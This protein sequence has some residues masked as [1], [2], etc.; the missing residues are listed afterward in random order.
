MSAARKAK[1]ISFVRRRLFMR[2]R[3]DTNSAFSV[4]P[5]NNVHDTGAAAFSRALPQ[6]TS[7][8]SLD[9]RRTVPCVCACEIAGVGGANNACD[10]TTTSLLLAARSSQE[11]CHFAP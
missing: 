3:P 1:S 8:T 6:T 5:G 7:L 11:R 10:Q 9:L 2:A 4:A